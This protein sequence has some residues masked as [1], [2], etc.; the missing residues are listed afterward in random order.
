M[1]VW[2]SKGGDLQSVLVSTTLKAMGFQE[3]L[4][5]DVGSVATC[6]VIMLVLR[7][8]HNGIRQKTQ[9]C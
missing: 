9:T 4:S 5:R 7:T 1:C 3:Q 6:V 8:K 2:G